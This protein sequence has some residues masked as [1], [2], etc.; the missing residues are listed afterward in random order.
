MTR[1]KRF[2]QILLFGCA[3]VSIALITVFSREKYLPFLLILGILTILTVMI[4]IRPAWLMLSIAL[5][6]PSASMIRQFESINI[7]GTTISLSGLAWAFMAAACVWFLV[8]HSSQV[9]IP[10]IIIPLL[11]FA[12][13]TLLRWFASAMPLTGLKDILFFGLPPLFGIFTLWVVTS[14]RGDPMRAMENLFLF[15][16]FIPI[17]LYLLCIPMGWISITKVGPVGIIESRSIALYLLIVLSLAL[18]RW[19]YG[20]NIQERRT[21]V[22]FGLLALAIILFTLSRMAGVTAIL[23]VSIAIL[24]PS[25]FREWLIGGFAA[26]LAA[27][28]I[29][30]VIPILRERFFFNPSSSDIWSVIL[31]LRTAGRNMFWPLTYHHAMANPLIGWGPGTSR[32]LVAQSFRGVDIAEYHPHNEYLQVFHDTGA[33]GLI[34]LLLAYLPL[35]V[36]F[37]KHWKASRI[38]KNPILEGCNMTAFLSILAIL[39]TSIT[40]NTL[41]YAFVTVPAFIL[42]AF[43]YIQNQRSLKPMREYPDPI[44]VDDSPPG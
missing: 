16:V 3:G 20:S 18:A 37:W 12:G 22:F 42:V 44:T 15:S 1:T 10:K 43:A 26:G 33:I 27:A 30:L 28:I 17:C 25:R 35:L 6:A 34:L 9:R 11:A 5:L 38:A 36:H 2:L 24:K 19:S 31:S 21:G 7:S 32:I 13:W 41:H 40:A 23:L 14:G 4:F 29:I 8:T 39:T